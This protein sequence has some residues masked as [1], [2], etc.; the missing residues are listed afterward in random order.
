L[1][2]FK[3]FNP[4]LNFFETHLNLKQEVIQQIQ[5]NKTND[6]IVR[7]KTITKVL[8]EEKISRT[9]FKTY[10]DLIRKYIALEILDF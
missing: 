9:K 5:E 6:E 4:G 10:L 1:K 8:R 3:R 2:S 7:L